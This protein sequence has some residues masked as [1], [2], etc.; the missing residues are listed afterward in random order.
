LGSMGTFELGATAI[1]IRGGRG[2][3]RADILRR[4]PGLALEEIA[5]DLLFPL[6]LPAVWEKLPLAAAA[7]TEDRTG[8]NDPLRRRLEDFDQLGLGPASL[9]AADATADLIAGSGQGDEDRLAVETADA[10]AAKGEAVNAQ[11][12]GHRILR[13]VDAEGLFANSARRRRRGTSGRLR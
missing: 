13:I 2:D 12:D 11:L 10:T 8:R 7:A 5:V 1:G 9:V 6:R 3:D 4:D